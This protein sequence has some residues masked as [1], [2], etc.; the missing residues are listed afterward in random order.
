VDASS[1]YF[2]MIR[3]CSTRSCV[4]TDEAVTETSQRECQRKTHFFYRAVVPDWME[5]V[6]ELSTLLY[7]STVIRIILLYSYVVMFY[8]NT[9]RY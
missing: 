6:F 4:P 3:I 8:I 1:S 9:Y 7:S 5:R 2:M